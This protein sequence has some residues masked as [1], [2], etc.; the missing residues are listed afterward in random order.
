MISEAK[1]TARTNWENGVWA[2]GGGGRVG[3]L[4]VSVN[5]RWQRWF[6]WCAGFFFQLT[7]EIMGLMGLS[8]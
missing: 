4:V 1:N 3:V 5:W 2:C 6:F 7:F 8:Y